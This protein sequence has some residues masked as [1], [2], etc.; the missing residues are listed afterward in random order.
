MFINCIKYIYINIFAF[1]ISRLRVIRYK[2]YIYLFYAFFIIYFNAFKRFLGESAYADN[3]GK[4]L[5]I[6]IINR[7]RK[8]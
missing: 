5:I 4:R 1:D 7:N 3:R 6:I 2:K 8:P